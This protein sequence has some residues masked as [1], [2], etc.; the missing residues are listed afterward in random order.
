MVN[1]VHVNMSISSQLLLQ[2]TSSSP[3]EQSGCPSHLQLF[4]MQIPDSV[5]LNSE[6]PQESVW[7]VATMVTPNMVTASN[8]MI[9]AIAKEG[10]TQI[11]TFGLVKMI[12]GLFRYS[13]CLNFTPTV[14]IAVQAVL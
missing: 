1:Y 11:P 10:W 12:S 8:V 7:P 4:G 2:P 13:Y 6:A 9:L 5:H 3:S 14:E